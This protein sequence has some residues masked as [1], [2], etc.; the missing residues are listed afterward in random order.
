VFVALPLSS[1]GPLRKCCV[2]CLE[3]VTRIRHVTEA[4]QRRFP[5]LVVPLVDGSPMLVVKTLADS[6]PLNGADLVSDAVVPGS[7]L[8]FVQRKNTSGELE[9]CRAMPYSETRGGGG[10]SPTKRKGVLVDSNNQPMLSPRAKAQ[11]SV[12]KPETV[13]A[14]VSAADSRDD[15]ATE[16]VPPQNKPNPFHRFGGTQHLSLASRSQK[17]TPCHLLVPFLGVET[18]GGSKGKSRLLVPSNASSNSGGINSL[19]ASVALAKRDAKFIPTLPI[20]K[21]PSARVRRATLRKLT[22]AS[23]SD[24]ELALPNA[25]TRQTCIAMDVAA[26]SAP[27]LGRGKL[28][29]LRGALAGAALTWSTLYLAGYAP[30]WFGPERSSWSRALDDD[31]DARRHLEELER[32]PGLWKSRLKS[33]SRNFLEVHQSTAERRVMKVLFINTSRTLLTGILKFGPDV[34]GPPRCV[35]GGCSAAVIDACLGVLAQHVSI[36]PCLT[37]NLDINY[38]EKIPL[39]SAVGVECRHE[40]TDGRKVHL[41]FK[42]F[43]LT[44][45]PDDERVFVEG[46]ALFLR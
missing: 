22:A 25:I 9:Q 5:Q 29:Y 19:D 24:R 21:K 42:L 15:E 44:D 32:T 6:L 26:D 28:L 18:R 7:T 34:E 35:H 3:G 16:T 46:H 31:P 38:R 17:N 30:L 10:T 2:P 40:D 45:N 36:V 41:S 33:S 11:E 20:L 1:E 12:S 23:R 37:A 4:I 13:A 43:K 39:G 14:P 27:L 8:A